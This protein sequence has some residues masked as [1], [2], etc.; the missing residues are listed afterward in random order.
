MGG[1]L[2]DVGKIAVPDQ[3]LNKPGPLTK[4]EFA[5]MK[6]HPETGKRM[7]EGIEFLRPA[8]PYVLYHHEQYDGSG[9]PYGLKGEEIPFEGRLLA[10]AD[11]FDA[12]ISDRPY[13]KGASFEK[14]LDELVKFSGRQFDPAVVNAFVSVWEN[15]VLDLEFL[16]T[17]KYLDVPVEPAAA[18]R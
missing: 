3:I 6:K 16:A 12:I 8:L 15:N 13:R 10:V 1:I 11:T 14:A 5:V 7:L 2:H 17:G 9:Y 18:R 4:D